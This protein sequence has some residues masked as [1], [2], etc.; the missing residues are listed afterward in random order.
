MN[1][2]LLGFSATAVAV[3]FAGLE[4]FPGP[5]LRLWKKPAAGFEKRMLFFSRGIC[6]IKEQ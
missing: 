4:I 2:I 5:V 3:I 1:A 6:Y